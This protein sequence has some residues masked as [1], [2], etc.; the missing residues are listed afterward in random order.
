MGEVVAGGS[1]APRMMRKRSLL[2]LAL[3]LCGVLHG[4]CI[5]SSSG[6]GALPALRS[7][8]EA[9]ASEFRQTFDEAK[10]QPRYVVALSPT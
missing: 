9:H 2:T 4:G 10:D 8:D 7:L 3:V 5:R 6:P 1:D